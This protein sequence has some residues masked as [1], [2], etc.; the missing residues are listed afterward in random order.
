MAPTPM[1][2]RLFGGAMQSASI[3]GMLFNSHTCRCATCYA[4]LALKRSNS[5]GTTIALCRARSIPSS[6][7]LENSCRSVPIAGSRSET[8]EGETTINGA[9]LPARNSRR[10]SNA[11]RC[12]ESS[13]VFARLRSSRTRVHRERVTD[14]HRTQR[15]RNRSPLQSRRSDHGRIEGPTPNR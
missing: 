9:E 15:C 10:N 12:R 11:S 7:R 1:K 5:T 8:A 3:M 14:L 2:R 13:S 4:S 6:G